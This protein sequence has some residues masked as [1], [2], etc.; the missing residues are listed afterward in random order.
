[1][2]LLSAE[3][4]CC[5]IWPDAQ[6]TSY[7]VHTR[8]A[9]SGCIAHRWRK[10]GQK[11]VKGNPHPRS[12]YKCTSTGCP[13]RKHVERSATDAGILVTTY[14]GMHNHEQLP[15]SGPPPG[16]PFAR[17]I[18]HLVRCFCATHT[19]RTW[20]FHPCMPPSVQE[21]S[22]SSSDSQYKL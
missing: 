2:Q 9:L 10:Y 6:Q 12:Y 1:M 16:K 11:V 21:M 5:K 7:G 14:E 4:A 3:F 17:R 20:C 18:T 15:Y 13:V 22:Q 8:C 19:E